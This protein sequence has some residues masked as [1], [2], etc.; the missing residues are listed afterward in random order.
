MITEKKKEK[1]THT[2]RVIMA[3]STSLNTHTPAQAH[4]HNRIVAIVI[5]APLGNLRRQ[6]TRVS[7]GTSTGCLQ[8]DHVWSV[9]D[10][11]AYG[12][13]GPERLTLYSDTQS[14][15]QQLVSPPFTFSGQSHRSM[16][17]DVS[18]VQ[19]WAYIYRSMVQLC[20]EPVWPSG[21]A[22]GW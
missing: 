2:H 21:K 11:A 12:K 16:V 9:S 18:G 5:V 13:Y 6:C 4:V 15:D 20:R 8:V 22:L 7:P 10:L 19:P 14:G 3:T 17:A 1:H